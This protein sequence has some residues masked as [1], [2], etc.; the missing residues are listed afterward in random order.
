VACRNNECGIDSV[1]MR[2]MVFKKCL[3]VI[4]HGS[5]PEDLSDR[6]LREIDSATYH[7]WRTGSNVSTTICIDY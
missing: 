5:T 7:R 6:P 1:D 2:I 3:R 4:S